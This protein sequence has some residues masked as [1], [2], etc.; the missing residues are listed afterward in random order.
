L[1]EFGGAP[2]T[3][4]SPNG[5]T[6]PAFYE[7]SGAGWLRTA[8]GGLLMTCGLT[9]V[10]APDE[11]NGQMLPLHGRA[12]HLPARQAAAIGRW[13]G[14][15]YEIT[16]SG[17]VE[18]TEIFRENLRLTRTISARLGKNR[19]ALHDVVENIGF[20]PAPHMLLYHFNFGFPLLDEA[21]TIKF[22]SRTVVAREAETSLDE[23][24]RWQSPQAGYQERVYYHQNISVDNR[25]WANVVIH[26]PR[27]P[28]PESECALSVRLSWA[29][30]T[31]PK[32]IQWK[33]PGADVHVLGIEPANCYVEGR[34]VERARG[35]LVIMEPGECLTYDLE[36][37]V[38]RDE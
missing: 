10:G 19:I 36:F 32:L 26:N 33:M 38:A 30:Q 28:L 20:E 4:Q 2:L 34:K 11:E 31:L 21:T 1:A 29:T 37:E 14:D 13:M 24:D 12:H 9:H 22:P 27:F 25:G 16:I 3:W 15:E 35:G 6:H 8:S 23:Y 7:A 5:E 18:E 17:V